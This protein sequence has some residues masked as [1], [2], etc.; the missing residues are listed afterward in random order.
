MR[1][2]LDRQNRAYAQPTPSQLGEITG[3]LAEIGARLEPR[4]R[5]EIE[6]AVAYWWPK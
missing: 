2:W 3:A 5:E 1:E 4:T 6:R